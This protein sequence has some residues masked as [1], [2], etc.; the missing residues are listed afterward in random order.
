M[1]HSRYLGYLLVAIEE[2]L[3]HGVSFEQLFCGMKSSKPHASSSAAAVDTTMQAATDSSEAALRKACCNLL[4]LACMML[5][6]KTNQLR[7]RMIVHMS[8]P[9][10][11]WHSQQN[12][13][14]RD[15]HSTSTWWLAQLQGGLWRTARAFVASLEDTVSFERLGFTLLASAEDAIDFKRT[16]TLEELEHIVDD[17][18]ELANLG[19][20]LCMSLLGE[21]LFRLVWVWRGWPMQSVLLLSQDH[22]AHCLDT[23]K[24]DLRLFRLVDGMTTAAAKKV[25][26]RSLFKLKSV[27]CLAGWIEE[28]GGVCD[29]SVLA[30][31]QTLHR[32][33]VA[34]QAIE[35]GFH[36]CRD[37][38]N[39][40]LNK[41]AI[42]R[43]CFFGLVNSKV[44]AGR[45]HFK[46]LSCDHQ[47]VAPAARVPDD[48]FNGHEVFKPVLR[49][50][51][52][53]LQLESIVGYRDPDWYS[54]G[55]EGL[56]VPHC[57]LAMLA[58][59]ES[60][61]QLHL[62]QHAWLSKFFEID[63]LL[64][65]RIEYGAP[66]HFVLAAPPD[67]C[68]IGWPAKAVVLDDTDVQCFALDSS[69][70]SASWLAVSSLDDWEAMSFRWRCPLW[71]QLHHPRVFYKVQ[72]SSRA[73][74]TST[75]APL[76]HTAA[77]R[78]FGSFGITAL[79][80][81]S[82]H[83]GLA[84]DAGMSLLDV[85][86][87][88]IMHVLKISENDALQYAS[89]RYKNSTTDS[90]ACYSELLACDEALYFMSKDEEEALKKQQ[91][92]HAKDAD[93]TSSFKAEWSNRMAKLTCAG[94]TKVP[95]T[96]K[97]KLL[98]SIKLGILSVPSGPTI[99]EA[100]VWQMLP[101][102]ASMWIERRDGIWR[103][104]LPGYPRLARSFLTYGHKGA[105]IKVLQTLWG[106]WLG[107]NL[108]ELSDCPVKG[109]FAAE[110]AVA[111]AGAASSSSA[112]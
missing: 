70:A 55:P 19:G 8:S 28:A 35:D 27:Q 36:V 85:L 13:T 26:G 112:A 34:T 50:G 16:R 11:S 63:N 81:I 2:D 49:A 3:L 101:P 95:A 41:K 15:A 80:R 53:S 89:A 46:G 64:V 91:E 68:A 44:L 32:R 105:A 14:L 88:L 42:P 47:P 57:D 6:V 66:W 97:T 12:S 62:L 94:K 25:A 77:R 106:H 18:D 43:N 100:E 103:G 109:L 22:R 31:V 99:T 98:K 20:K 73:F 110:P 86:V 23:F 69:A 102:A 1:W 7:Q 79:R 37:L 83:V 10:E 111:S 29:D 96:H 76:L 60:S 51:A 40:H 59:L 21:F 87:A 71:Q 56:M 65:R 38:E 104:K 5:S 4:V 84:L 93:L 78:A 45:H 61:G 82:A 33:L 72:A 92:A 58:E 17:E 24:D 67:T 90:T 107:D 74:T 108:M 9:L 54:P 52:E 30:A 75:V 39:R 48:A